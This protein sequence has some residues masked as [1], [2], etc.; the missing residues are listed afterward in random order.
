MNRPV[1]LKTGRRRG[2]GIETALIDPGKPRQN[3]TAESFNGKLRDECLNMEWFRNRTEARI[4]SEK[5]P[6]RS[7][8]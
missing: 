1:L 5:N 3:G 2:Q 7:V 8:R 4:V 6:S